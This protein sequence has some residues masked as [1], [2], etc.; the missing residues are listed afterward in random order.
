MSQ[1]VPLGPHARHL[2]IVG[3]VA[4]LGTMSPSTEATTIASA[5]TVIR[6]ARRLEQP[7]LAAAN[8]WGLVYS[9][10]ANAFL[11]IPVEG[12]S[13]VQILSH[14]AD[15]L[16][17]DSVDLADVDALNSAYD[18]SGDRLLVVAGRELVAIPVRKNGRLDL[19]ATM[20][21]FD[22]GRL[23]IDSPAG[24]AID[25][26]S[27]ALFILDRATPRLV[28]VEPAPDGD[29]DAGVVSDHELKGV[30][31]VALQ[32]LAFDPTTGDLLTLGGARNLYR[33]SA[34][35]VLLE[36]H[37]ISKAHL[38]SPAGLVFAPTGDLT[39]DPS[40]HSLY[41]ADGPAR[42]SSAGREAAPG[43]PRSRRASQASM[44]SIVELRFDPA[45]TAESAATATT[46]AAAAPTEQ[47]AATTDAVTTFTSSVVRTV[48]TSQWS[49]PAPDPSDVVYMPATNTLRVVDSEVEETVGGVTLWAGVN[50]WETNLDGTV[51]G[52]SNLTPPAG[53]TNEPTG[54][55]V[56]LANGHL[57]YSDDRGSPRKVWEIN[58]GGDGLYHTAD[59][60]RS[61]FSTTAFGSTDPEDVTY[62]PGEGVLYLADG[63]NSE[64]YRIAPGAD[65]IFNGIPPT[66]DDV[67]TQFDTS[68][69]TLDPECLTVNTDTHN[70]YIGGHL[71]GAIQELSTDGVQLQTIDI[72]AANALHIAG[73]GFGP[74]STDPSASRLYLVQRGV[75]NGTDPNENDGKLWELTLPGAAVNLAPSVTAGIDQAIVLPA[76]A[77]LDGAVT[78]DGL[79]NPPAA[80]TTTWSRQSGP[81]TVTFGNVS[82]VDTTATFSQSGP[83]VLRLTANDGAL[84]STDDVAITVSPVGS[85]LAAKAAAIHSSS[86]ASSYAFAP[87]TASNNRLYVVF[88]ST[89]I[90][91]GTAPS[92]TSVSG[93]GLA[94][95]EI[96][97]PGGL[98]YSGTPGLRRIQAWRALVG[99]GAGTGSI[100]ISLDGT[101]TGMDAAL[102]EFDG[103]D[104]SGTNGSGA[105]AQSATNQATSATALTVTLSAF[106]S[107][108]NR[109]VA[110]FNH[111]VA[112]ATTEESGYTELDEGSHSSPT[113]GAEC[114]WHASTADTTPSASWLTNAA[115]GGFAIEVRAASGPPGNQ[116]PT[117]S[118]GPDQNITLPAF[119][120]LD[121]TVMDDGL[122]NPPAA[123]TKTWSKLSGPGTVTFGNASAV[124]TTASF[125]QS[126]PYVL[127]LTASDSLLSSSDEVAVT[128]NPVGQVTLSVVPK[129]AIHD[130]TDASSYAF[131]PVT[132]S[133]NRLYV[134]FMSTSIAT[135]TAP[136]ATSVSGAGLA[137]TE[138]GTPGGLLYSGTPGLRRIQAW[139]A[140]VGSN[141]A[142]GSIAI[143][144]NGTSTGMDAV[145]LEF[146]GVDASG[147]NG[148][149]AIVQSAS[150]KA[151]SATALTVTLSAF[152][153]PANRP[154]AFFNHRVAEATTHEPGYTEL[155]EGSHSSPTAGAECEWH[156]ST[157]DTTP[158][159]SW[160][161]AANAGGFA[162]E[163]KAQP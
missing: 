73:I 85:L 113:A 6:V 65:G 145:L 70:L 108:G 156:A 161:T 80:V 22:F 50:E 48:L 28:R 142:T 143:S 104:T 137:F 122:P 14:T 131:A 51:L 72:S 152:G 116:A 107:V 16:G 144:L 88:V 124:D 96:G 62:H 91:T 12:L 103:V 117:V 157:A 125:S 109:P 64:V 97:T 138:I 40:A 112:E 17:V 63:L 38:R 57:F 159:A 32:G 44:G 58:P 2:R 135:G 76:F 151:S 140:L 75:D 13:A 94:F 153:S 47:V 115:A 93:A 15:P 60:I 147:I 34:A 71:D 37:D 121:G 101:S 118:A 77:N 68:A 19:T 42:N 83:Y 43:T 30:P 21:R 1:A 160:V 102:L 111:R 36:T 82:A 136:S 66:G 141:A 11:V 134:V 35:G 29:F 162:I 99:S 31:S 3:L 158:S 114:E 26:E 5:Q 4:A 25:A 41:V 39:D 87:V 133:N 10:R 18:P 52:T 105:V 128:V 69:H 120:S 67:V 79:P 129:A 27:G 46:K 49:P 98:L 56:N 100:A 59:D 95:T 106:A 123:V 130:P 81:G 74:G 127:R 84:I 132:A 86:D 89:S 150:N 9:P 24:L 78:D 54:V 45:P 23:G 53:F 155:D 146:D 8:P 149:G 163:V 90:T 61:W 154:V 148:F 33:F 139:R 20:P 110:F 55:S 119:A 92:A 7:R 126:G